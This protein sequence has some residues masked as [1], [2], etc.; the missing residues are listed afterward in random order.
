MRVVLIATAPPAALGMDAALR[1]TGHEVTALLALRT[2]PGRFGPHAAGGLL[3]AAPGADVVFVSTPAR[4]AALLAV[5][6]PDAAVC[7]SFPAR[8]P[9]A[10]L[11]VPAHGIVNVHPGRLPR[12]R[13]P[14]PMGWALRNG[15]PE[16][17]LTFHRM[18]AEFDMGAVLATGSVPVD[19]DEDVEATV[20]GFGRLGALV[21][22]ALARLAAGDPGDPQDER[23]A[24][25]AGPFEEAYVEVDWS[26]T[27]LEVHR[28]ARAWR[29]APPSGG[30]R[31]ALTTLGGERVRLVRTRLHGRDGG[32]PVACG[33][34]P[35]WVLETEPADAGA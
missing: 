30:R 27:A 13:G 8:I 18:T 12:Y 26:R 5:Y 16:L 6:A 31:G 2:P 19:E 11:A 23:E 7:S 3:A 21:D 28:Q 29:L 32:T 22:V 15:D 1:A 10:A 4:L 33:D 35:L 20:A 9:A 34:G 14:N 25:R 24:G 17:H